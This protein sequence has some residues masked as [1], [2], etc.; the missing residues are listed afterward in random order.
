MAEHFARM[1][2]KWRAAMMRDAAMTASARLIGD[3]LDEVYVNRLDCRAH[4]SVYSLAASLGMTVP[5]V[6][7]GLKALRKRGWIERIST[8]NGRG[9]VSVYRLEFSHIDKEETAESGKNIVPFNQ[10][11][12]ERKHNPFGSKRGKK[13]NWKGAKNP[14]TEPYKGTYK[15]AR[16]HEG[17]WHRDRRVLIPKGGHQETAWRRWIE[18]HGYGELDDLGLLTERGEV[19]EY[20]LPFSIPEYDPKN[21]EHSISVGW[22]EQRV[23]LLR[24]TR[25]RHG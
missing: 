11:N 25:A 2:H 16:A 12:G 9:N 10:G 8:G 14:S 17:P 24:S 3:F 15:D 13:P 1:R 7:D 21:I 22:F 19:A 5:T 18:A 20:V 6:R 4:P 23:D